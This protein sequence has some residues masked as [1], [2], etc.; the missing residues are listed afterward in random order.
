MATN[1]L[2]LIKR[3]RELAK[4]FEN[5]KSRPGQ[6]RGPSI[7]SEIGRMLSERHPPEVVAKIMKS[8]G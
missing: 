4:E 6:R 3:L 2:P 5:E 1:W 8:G 7:V